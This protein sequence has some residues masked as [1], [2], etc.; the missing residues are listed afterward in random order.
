MFHTGRSVLFPG[1]FIFLVLSSPLSGFLAVSHAAEVED[2]PAAAIPG[3]TVQ[4]YF[5]NDLFYDEDSDYTNAVQLRVI[6]PDL[7]TLAE[8]GFLPEGVSN[9]LGKVPFPGSRG[10]VQYNISAGFGQ[11][12]YTP[13]D[14]ESRLL[15]K[16]DRPYAGY[17]YGLLALHAKRHNRLDTVELAAGVIGPSSLAE[18]AQN[19]VHRIRSIDTAKGWK[20]QLRDEPALMLTWS[21][22]WRLNAEAVPGGWGWDFLPQVNASIG[23]PYTRA[24][25][26]AE[27]RFGWNLP[28]DYGSSTIR[29]GAGISR[30]LEEGVQ[31]SITHYK[32]DNFLDNFSVY[33]FTGADGYAVAWNSFLDGNVWKDSH[34]VDK[35][36]LAGELSGGIA[37]L[38]Y[39]FQISY[40]HVY[41]AKEF[42]GQN[43][44]TNYGSITV[45]YRF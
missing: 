41:R 3:P 7:R 23:N 45:G 32:S 6:S 31:G 5:E 37:V 22:I 36:P 10:A 28:P 4:I 35:F 24:G 19:E 40:T 13:R 26:G 30:P 29:P 43:K 17:L 27:V 21:R 25:L 44:D 39:D 33:L 18:N 20:H 15:Q 9:L 16:E 38:L 14:T 34:S 1:L 2:S 12:I 42:H 8:N 11:Q